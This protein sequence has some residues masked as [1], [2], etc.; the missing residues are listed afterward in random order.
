MSLDISNNKKKAGPSVTAHF[1]L[2][3]RETVSVRFLYTQ[4]A[5]GTMGADFGERKE[6]MEIRSAVVM[7][8]VCS[9]GAHFQQLSVLFICASVYRMIIRFGD[10]QEE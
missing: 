8:G 3:W 1:R 4:P 2:V 7:T 10:E 5:W 6:N 9:N